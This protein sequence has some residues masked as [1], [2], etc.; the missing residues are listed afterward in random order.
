MQGPS[1]RVL[2]KSFPLSPGTSSSYFRLIMAKDLKNTAQYKAKDL[3]LL[4]QMRKRRRVQGRANI[5]LM[6]STRPH[7]SPM[8]NRKVE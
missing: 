8:D 5:Y 7:V 6:L 4:L 1:V 3:D 2:R